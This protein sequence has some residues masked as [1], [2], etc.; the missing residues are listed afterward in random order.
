MQATNRQT[1]LSNNKKRKI[2]EEI[3]QTETEQINDDEET[4]TDIE[5]IRTT[6]KNLPDNEQY[7]LNLFYL[8]NCNIR[9]ISNI[10]NIP[11][12]TVK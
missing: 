5:K 8:E 7:I 6:M 12:G 10:L 2:K 3:K 4:K 11:T 9:E 1:G